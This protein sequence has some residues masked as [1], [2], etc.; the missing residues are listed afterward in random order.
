[1][2]MELV[3][4]FKWFWVW[5]DAAEETWLEKM[6]QE[7]YHLSYVNLPCI[8][9][10]T[11]NEPRNYVYRLDYQPFHK[12]DREEYL[13]LFQDAGWEHLGN[14][15]AWQ[16]FRKESSREDTPEIFTDFESK[17]SKY[18][19]IL[20]VLGA[21]DLILIAIFLG[22]LIDDVSYPWWGSIP[23]WIILVVLLLL[24]YAITRIVIRIKQLRK[25]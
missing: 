9:T 24:T 6:S 13:Q 25:F 1:M 3:S 4:K 18:R 17:I 2:E 21:F 10:F 16:Y 15:S 7:G 22:R 23:Q 5:Q 12:K 14:M 11:V 20:T 19:R 8:Y